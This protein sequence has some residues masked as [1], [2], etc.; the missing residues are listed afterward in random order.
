MELAEPWIEDGAVW[1]LESRPSEAGRGV[2]VRSDPWSSP[3]DVTPEGFNVR[4]KVHEYGGGACVLRRAVFFSNFDD[5]RLYRQEAGSA[6]EAITPD[7]RD[8]T[9]TPM[10]ACAATARGS[11]A[12][13]NGTTASGVVNELVVVATDGAEV[14]QII[15]GGRDF[16]AAPRLSP[17]GSRLAWIS[18]DLPWM[19]WDG[20]ELWVATWARRNLGTRARSWVPT[21]PNRSGNRGGARSASS[22]S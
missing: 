13:G 22:T 11:S 2:I 18:W 15:A 9:G 4:T 1:W 8:A 16:Y 20:C 6:P 10:P 21:E 7:R 12:C 17:D 19:P 3:A 14:P 5:Q